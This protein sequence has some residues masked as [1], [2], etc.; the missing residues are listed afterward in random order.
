MSDD[1]IDYLLDQMRQEAANAGT[2]NHRCISCGRLITL[3]RPLLC[4]RCDFIFQENPRRFGVKD[5]RALLR[6]YGLE[7]WE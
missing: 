2:Y 6:R 1:E 4:V 5:R 7:D 3:D